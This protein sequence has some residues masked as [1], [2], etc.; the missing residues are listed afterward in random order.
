MRLT[1]LVVLLACAPLAHSQALP[2]R[3][4]LD[5][6]VEWRLIT[7]GKAE[8]EWNQA[9]PAQPGWEVRFT[10]ESVGL[11]SKLFKVNDEYTASLTPSLC[12][13]SVRIVAHEGSRQREA[14]V[15][16]EGGQARYVERNLT[17]NAIL[18]SKQIEIP[19]CVH[20]VIGGLYYL[21]TLTLEPGQSAQ[22]PVTDGKKFA[23]VRVEAQAREDVKTA[24]GAFKTIRY[25]IYLFDGVLYQRSARLDVWLTEDHRRL[26]V[27]VRVRMP[28]TIG[29][30]TLQL[31]KAE[32][33]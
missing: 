28:F 31:Q 7:A 15:G 18:L 9:G 23:M 8:V 27:Q 5:Y 3:E 13:R 33:T 22:M 19:A 2:Y 17:N 12:A 14:R 16:F 20:D 26:P 6:N 24:A 21:R 32:G 25:E 29:T 11:V 4:K 30:I 10:L 1:P